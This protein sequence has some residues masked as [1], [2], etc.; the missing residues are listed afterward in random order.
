[1]KTGTIGNVRVQASKGSSNVHNFSHNLYTSC[2]F[3]EVSPTK[4]LQCDADSKTNLKQEF[5]CYLADLNAPTYGHVNVNFWHYFVEIEDLFSIFPQLL[6]QTKIFNV[7]RDPN[8]PNTN[9]MHIPVELPWVPRNLLC[10]FLLIGAQMTVYKV[11]TSLN[12]SR[13]VTLPQ[14]QDGNTS[15]AALYNTFWANFSSAVNDYCSWKSGLVS[16]A[17]IPAA[18]VTINGFDIGQASIP[19]D[20]RALVDCSLLDNKPSLMRIPLGNPTSRYFGE[21][22]YSD[23]TI[24]LNLDGVDVAPVSLDGA[25]FI[26]ERDFRTPTSTDTDPDAYK[27]VFA[28]RMHA[29]GKRLF[30]IFKGLEFQED[31]TDDT[32]QS[33]APFMATFKAYWNSFGLEY[34]ENYENT[35]AAMISRTYDSTAGEMRR[36]YGLFAE[37]ATFT[38]ITQEDKIALYYVKGFLFHLGTMW[39]TDSQDFVSAQQHEITNSPSVDSS[40]VRSFT[41]LVNAFSA[42]GNPVLETPTEGADPTGVFGTN[43]HAYIDNIFHGQLSS[44]VLKKLYLY[45][46]RN[47]IAGKRVRELLEMQGLGKWADKQ[48]I[49]FIGHDSK[50]VDFDQVVST[51]NTEN[52]GKGDLLGGRGGRGQAYQEGKSHFYHNDNIGYL[53]T[54][55]AVVPDAGYTQ[56]QNPAFDCLKKYDFFIRDYDGLGMEATRIKQVNGERPIKLL[57]DDGSEPSQDTE[58]VFGFAPRMSRFKYCANILSGHFA[59][60]SK[61]DYFLTY[62]TDKFIDV[63][64][65]STTSD[66]YSGSLVGG[67]YERKLTFKQVFPYNEFPLAG[68]HWRFVTR[69]P[70]LGHYARIFAALGDDV[71]RYAGLLQSIAMLRRGWEYL[72]NEE[73]GFSIMATVSIRQRNKMLQIADSYETTDDS[74]DG[75]TN[76]NTS[77]A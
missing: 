73:D 38:G 16:T 13:A 68:P 59:Q 3:G 41:P 1:M 52:N 30:K 10:M 51:A 17:F 32:P 60:R 48:K 29:F 6:A 43:D 33:I 5:L 8:D 19:I 65:I 2:G 36:F 22:Y 64:E 50:N 74:N 62:N 28:F 49:R 34:Y 21:H 66:N 14:F 40:F 55:C 54:L 47:T 69:Y 75:K 4:C 57:N 27:Y 20:V 58:R 72:N 26:I 11:T 77:K 56:S 23:G 71:Q 7:G 76:M 25:D 39:F 53:I 37:D 61:R 24:Q 45:T 63:G 67:T 12:G 9:G 18:P 15:Q 44:E 35:Y 31:F 46:N 42:N 70:W